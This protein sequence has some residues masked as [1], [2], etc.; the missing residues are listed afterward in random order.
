MPYYVI[1]VKTRNEKDY[2]H[3]ATPV[4]EDAGSKL[5]WPR[6]ALK[7][8]RKGSWREVIAPI[9]PG[10]VFLESAG[11]S[12]ELYHYIRR[13]P[14]FIRFLQSN[15]NITPLNKRDSELLLHFLS[16]GETVNKSKVFFDEHNKIRAVSGPL[17]GLEGRIVKVDKRKGRAKVKLELCENSFLVDF[18]FAD[19]EIS[20][21]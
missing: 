17:K 3:M 7:I 5:I 6:R 2:F 14:G 18:G 10:Y 11:I 15:Q 21:G 1:Q 19:I 4:A 12:M 20:T 8:R 13:I 9:F 16:F